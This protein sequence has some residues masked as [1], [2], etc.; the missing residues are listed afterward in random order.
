MIFL[1]KLIKR[2][3]YGVKCI[4]VYPVTE[5]IHDDRFKFAVK[6]V[7]Q[8]VYR[9]SS[10]FKRFSV[11]PVTEHIH[12]DRFKFAV[13][14]V[15]QVVYRLSSSFGVCVLLLRIRI[16]VSGLEIHKPVRAVITMLIAFTAGDRITEVNSSGNHLPER[17]QTAIHSC[18]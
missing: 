10:G 5:H 14:A 13:K 3:K 8:V 1:L 4:F 17:S 16:E 18:Q 7:K 2:R 6:A 11:Y 12:D 9:L 15:K